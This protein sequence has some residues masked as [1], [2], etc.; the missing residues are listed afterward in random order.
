MSAKKWTA[1]ETVLL[2]AFNLSANGQPEFSEWDLTVESWRLD[3][4]RF[5]LKGYAQTYPD[6]KRVMM[7]IM[8]NKPSSPVQQKYLEKVRPNT[9][10]LTPLGKA[11]AQRLR[12]GEVLLTPSRNPLSV[13]DLYETVSSYVGRPEFRR[14]QEAPEEPRDWSSA[15]AFLGLSGKDSGIDPVERLEEIQK[16]TQN[17]MDWCNAKELVFLTKGSGQGG[18]P[19]HIR[20]LSLLQDFL[21]ALIYRFPRQLRRR[22]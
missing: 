11:A 18:E 3:N 12:S 9:Y 17:A 15:V 16:A 19:I 4:G 13:R 14:W 5:G 10:R 7:E 20:E 22:K 2:A 1:S 6:H 21:Q 8:G